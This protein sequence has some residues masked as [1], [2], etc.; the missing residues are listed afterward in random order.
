MKRLFTGLGALL[1]LA[2]RE[3]AHA[4]NQGLPALAPRG[5]PA[6]TDL[7]PIQPAAGTTLLSSRASDMQNFVTNSVNGQQFAGG[8]DPTGVA[9]STAAIQAA[10]NAGG[11]WKCNGV[12]K[13]TA[14]LNVTA[15][16]TSGQEITGSS[17]T[18]VYSTAATPT[19]GRCTIQPSSAVTT[20]FKI[21][22]VSFGGYISNFVVKNITLDMTNMPS[23]SVGFL[24]GQTFDNTYD[25]IRVIGDTGKVAWKFGPGAFLTTVS[26]SHATMVWCLGTGT[27]NPTTITL[28]NDD[29]FSLGME[30]CANVTTVGGAIQP[31]YGDTGTNTV[32]YVPP[33]PTNLVGQPTFYA[34]TTA[35]N[36]AYGLPSGQGMYVVLGGYT[37]NAQNLTSVGTDWEAQTTLASQCSTGGTWSGGSANDGT[38]GCLPAVWAVQVGLFTIGCSFDNPVLYNLY[39]YYT[40]AQGCDVRGDNTGAF[41]SL[42]IEN[43]KHVFN[44]TVTLNNG[45]GLFGYSDP[46]GATQTFLLSA[47]T[48]GLA[49]TNIVLK[50]LVD[51]Q[52]FTLE[53]SNAT[54]YMICTSNATIG[55]SNCGVGWG[56]DWTGFSDGFVT[57]TYDFNSATGAAIF[58]GSVTSPPALVNSAYVQPATDATDIFQIKNVAGIVAVDCGTNATPANSYCAFNNAMAV[59]GYSDTFTTKQYSLNGANG[60]LLSFGSGGVGY[61]TGSGAGGAVTQLTSRTTGVTLNKETGAITLFAAAG[62]ATPATFTVADSTV[63]ATDTVNLSVKSGTN[64]YLALVT[65]VAAGSFQIT[66]YTTGGTTSDSPV[67]SFAVLKGATS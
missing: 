23:A 17:A 49:N 2:S 64:T 52:T 11:G 7:I 33:G 18:G 51:G 21:D 9:D 37:L 15:L 54:P 65:G 28:V 41:I 53:S 61:G 8:A 16:V 55:A 67:I 13:T 66:F 40:N 27:Q 24:H 26:N 34:T 60:A 47:A 4:Q 57:R 20:A 5:T 56:A 43:A 46:A 59:T 1:A 22:G 31:A 3:P 42:D 38:H 39:L 19:A 48:G 58:A 35:L 32:V 63:V 29:L 44:Q 62:S 36:A 12:Y 45:Q 6:A 25:N 30:Q 10:I 14:T 50:P